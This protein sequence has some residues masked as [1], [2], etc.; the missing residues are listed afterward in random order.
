MFGIDQ[1][2]DMLITSDRNIL[3]EICWK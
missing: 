2:I 1:A 3:T